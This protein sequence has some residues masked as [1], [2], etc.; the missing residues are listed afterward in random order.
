MIPIIIIRIR[1][2]LFAILVIQDVL[3]NENEK[4]GWMPKKVLNDFLA[5]R[6]V[7]VTDDPFD[8]TPD[9]QQ[10]NLILEKATKESN[11]SSLKTAFV[12]ALFGYGDHLSRSESNPYFF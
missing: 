10:P 9:N 11:V 7:H 2:Q 8:D 1:I 3:K 5:F 12:S 6:H 4:L